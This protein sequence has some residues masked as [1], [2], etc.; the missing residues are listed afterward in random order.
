MHAC[1][2]ERGG[3][4]S[5]PTPLHQPVD[6]H[7]I[8][9]SWDSKEQQASLMACKESHQYWPFSWVESLSFAL[10]IRVHLSPH[11]AKQRKQ[12]RT[13][14]S[15]FCSRTQLHKAPEVDFKNASSVHSHNLRSSS[16]NLFV[17]RPLTEAGK[18][19]FHYR[20]AVLWNS[21]PTEVKKKSTLNSFRAQCYSSF[22]IFM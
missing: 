12:S 15:R 8:W 22:I 20:G 3:A 6:Y 19:S 9:I 1:L 18:R 21:L 17:H 4:P 10:P 16:H 5:V 2:G 11:S 13:Y 14:S 7:I